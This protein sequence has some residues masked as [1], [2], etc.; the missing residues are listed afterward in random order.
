MN[1]RIQVEH[2]VTEEAMGI[3]L[4]KWQ[5]RIANGETLDFE[6]KHVKCYQHAIECRINAEDTE[7]N[8]APC[9]GEINLYYAPG[10]YGV[11]VD[12]H[13]YGGYTIPPYYDSMI[14]KLIVCANTRSEAIGRMYRALDEYIIRGV[15]TTIPF[16]KKVMM[17]PSFKEG[18]ITTKY[19]KSFLERTEKST[20]ESGK[21][22]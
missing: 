16:C 13:V 1:T 14:G 11:R 22:L 7:Q 8:F 10:G 4:V 2:T 6:Q 5:I 3:D 12:S 9:P 19:V 17:D 18:G 15:K 21:N 20:L